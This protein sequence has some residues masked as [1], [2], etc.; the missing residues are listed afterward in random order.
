MNKESLTCSYDNNGDFDKPMKL[1]LRG[2]GE[3]GTIFESDFCEQLRGQLD[4]LRL[5][6]SV[7]IEN[8][9]LWVTKEHNSNAYTPP[10]TDES[11]ILLIVI[12]GSKTIYL[13]PN[14]KDA[15]TFKDQ[16]E[17]P[18]KREKIPADFAQFWDFGENLTITEEDI[19]SSGVFSKTTLG[20]GDALLMPRRQLHSVYTS[21]NTVMLSIDLK[22]KTRKFT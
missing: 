3:L 14:L 22:V 20:I 7:K 17:R 9:N 1:G 18:W 11:D 16:E 5:Q 19:V 15:T 13:G 21:P 4:H 12:E 10:H 6:L 2:G 8:C